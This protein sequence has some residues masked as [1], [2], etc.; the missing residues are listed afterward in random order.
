MSLPRVVLIRGHQANSWHLRPWRHLAGRFDVV[1][2]RTRRNWFDTASLGTASEQA[3]ALRDVLP[4]GAVFD[5]VARIPGDRYL[6]PARA[7]HGAAIV[8][9]QD[10]GFWY[11]MQ[12]ARLKER[13]G[14]KLVLTCWETIPF[15]D[16]YRNARTRRYRRLALERTDLFLAATQRA[17]RC[18]ELEG[19]D[20]ARLAVCPPGVDRALFR[21]E[22]PAEPPREHLVVSPARLVWEKGH[23][24]LLRAVALLRRDGAGTL[25]RVLVIGA[26]PEDRRLQAYARELG[27]GDLVEVRTA[28]PYAEMPKLYTRASALWLGS[29]PVWFW[30]EQF[31]MVLAEAMAAR[32]P[33]VTTTSGAIP[34]VVGAGATLVAPG[35]WVGLAAALRD[36][37]L[38]SAP[39]ARA[40]A[41]ER[42]LAAYDD[43]AMAERLAGHYERLLA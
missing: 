3:T 36:G 17:A 4:K 28:V 34:E 8:H 15:L 22:E 37:V 27:V 9:S 30:E 25:P 13:L 38:R 41:D 23:Q 12:A 35:D 39:G 20:P 26:G 24:D 2:L 32:L 6:R 18:L 33:I 14:F 31:G 5:Q 19:A 10:L 1:A 42:L 29:L 43:R 16:A 11:T 21:P 40:P 7:L